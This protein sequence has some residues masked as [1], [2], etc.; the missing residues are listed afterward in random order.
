MQGI[1]NLGIRS[2]NAKDCEGQ[3]KDTFGNNTKCMGED[4]CWRKLFLKSV[5]K[6]KHDTSKLFVSDFNCL[7][8]SE[9][10]KHCYKL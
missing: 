1:L 2:E 3:K 5:T 8:Y 6:I 4:W 7:W 10:K 9:K